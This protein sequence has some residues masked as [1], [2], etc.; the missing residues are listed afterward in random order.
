MARPLRGQEMPRDSNGSGT[1]G[2]QG[3]LP[4]AA[5]ATWRDW[6]GI[7]TVAL[8]LSFLIIAADSVH[9]LAHG[10]PP[11]P[12][13][14]VVVDVGQMGAPIAAGL[15]AVALVRGSRRRRV[16]WAC[17]LGGIALAAW[18]WFRPYYE[19]VIMR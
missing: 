3:K 10:G 11:S 18:A 1:G 4:A 13:M 17:F 6:A 9:V 12:A 7:A 2:E 19:P 14:Q 15:G 16:A 8:G 5:P